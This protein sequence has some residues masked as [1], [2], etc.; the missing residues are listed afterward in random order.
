MKKIGKVI[1]ILVAVV[2]CTTIFASAASFVDVS[3]DA[4]YAEAAER[5]AWTYAFIAFSALREK[6]PNS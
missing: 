1:N 3:A 2:L 5:M 4:Y 6:V